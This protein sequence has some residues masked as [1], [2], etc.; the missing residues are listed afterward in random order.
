MQQRMRLLRHLDPP[1]GYGHIRFDRYSAYFADPAAHGIT[2]LR[3]ARPYRAI[4]YSLAEEDLS[5]LAFHFDA[6]YS[7]ASPVYA[8]GMRQAVRA[9]Q[10]CGGA[11]L[12]LYLSPGAMRIVDTRSG[13]AREL[14]FDGLAANL[15][16]L[17]DA[18]QTVRALMEVPSVCAHASEAQVITL[19]DQ[20]VEQGLMIRAGQQYLS[21]AVVRERSNPEM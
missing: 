17:C 6:E 4:Y 3:P 21:L 1:T 5:D 14:T 18:A 7:D 20:F 15:Y 10:A 9:W 12:D 13:A 8:Q 16:L 2:Q 11:A 19:L